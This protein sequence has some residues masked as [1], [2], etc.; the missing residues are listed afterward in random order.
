MPAVATV[1]APRENSLASRHDATRQ[2]GLLPAVI[3]KKEGGLLS[4]HHLPRPKMLID[5]RHPRADVRQNFPRNRL[6]LQ[7]QFPRADLLPILTAQGHDLVAD[8]ATG[9]AS[10]VE[11]NLVH[12]HPPPDRTTLPPHQQMTS[13]GMKPEIAVAVPHRHHRAELPGWN[14]ISRPIT[15]RASAPHLTK[16]SHTALPGQHGTKP[17]IP[18]VVRNRRNAVDH[19]TQPHQ[20]G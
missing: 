2:T 12:R 4:V 17:Q 16:Q 9:Y 13:V 11:N 3:F 6:G 5:P 7:R 1:A 14:A 10:D 19:Q 20:I 15:H 18:R 8:A